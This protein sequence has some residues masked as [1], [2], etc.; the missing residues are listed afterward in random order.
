MKS[1]LYNQKGEKVGEVD[2]PED[3]FKQKINPDHIYQA[4]LY[5]ENLK[6]K[7]IAK[8]KDRSEVRGGGRKPWRQK[9]TGRARVGSI[10]TPVWRHGGVVFGPHNRDY[11]QRLPRKMKNIAIRD[12]LK[13]RILED[14]LI[15]VNIPTQDISQPKTKI[16]S[17][18]F[19]KLGL[20]DNQVLIVLDKKFQNRNEVVKSIR[21]LKNVS[22]CYVDQINPYIVLTHDCI[23]AQSDVFSFLTNICGGERNV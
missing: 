9:G 14:K 10:R 18:F 8:T 15:L 12:V 17:S 23:V 11:T 4:V 7:P 5:Y 22:Y 19:K 20:L 21:N 6:R 2:L 1:A 16:F 13:T 3:V